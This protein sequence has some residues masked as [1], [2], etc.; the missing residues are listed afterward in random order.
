MRIHYLGSTPTC[1]YRH[2]MITFSLKERCVVE[3]IEKAAGSCGW[4]QWSYFADGYD[5]EQWVYVVVKD[6]D[7]YKDFCSLYKDIKQTESAMK[8]ARDIMAGKKAKKYHSVDDAFNDIT[9][10]HSDLSD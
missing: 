4:R 3:M 2:A 7:D 6:H 5:G 1:S 9:G 8:E 10:S